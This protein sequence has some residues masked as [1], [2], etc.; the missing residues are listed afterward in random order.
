MGGASK[1]EILR[2]LEAAN[3]EMAYHIRVF[4]DT[5]A[6]R[7]GYKAHDGLEAVHYYLVN[8]Y[9]WLPSVVKALSTEDL[10]FLLA[11]EMSGWTVPK[12]AKKK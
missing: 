9:N 1:Y 8:K 12:A 10:S 5:L 2:N 3:G 4:G 7:E 6:E 11:E